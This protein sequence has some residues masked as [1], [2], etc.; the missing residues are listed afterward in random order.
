M[1]PKF[2]VGLLA[3]IILLVSSISQVDAASRY[4]RGY[5]KSSGTY[6][7]PHFK[8]QP[9]SYK[10]DNYSSKGNTNPFTGKKGRVR[11]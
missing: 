3:V 7:Q 10:F 1:M 11:W 8:T 2:I 5:F 6:V 9:N 4:Q